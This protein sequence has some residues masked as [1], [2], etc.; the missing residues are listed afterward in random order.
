MR[1]RVDHQIM[2]AGTLSELEVQLQAV[3]TRPAVDGDLSNVLLKRDPRRDKPLVTVRGDIVFEDGR[4]LY[5]RS[6]L[7]VS[8]HEHGDVIEPERSADPCGRKFLFLRDPGVRLVAGQSSRLIRIE[9]E[10][11]GGHG[12]L[13]FHNTDDDTECC[14]SHLHCV[15]VRQVHGGPLIRHFTAADAAEVILGA[16]YEDGEVVCRQF[17][18]L[19]YDT[20]AGRLI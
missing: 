11:I 6:T 15:E 9:D 14:S 1:S 20:R 3:L 19:G 8:Q 17:R 10:E 2:P 5:I 7:R 18:Q 4:K 12:E 13:H 16:Y